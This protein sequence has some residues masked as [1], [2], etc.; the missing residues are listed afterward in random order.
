MRVEILLGAERSDCQTLSRVF[1]STCMQC[2]VN[3]W[4]C[5]FLNKFKYQ[6]LMPLIVLKLA[7]TI[8]WS[9]AFAEVDYNTVEVKKSTTPA[10]VVRKVSSVFERYQARSG[11]TF[12]LN[13]RRTSGAYAKEQ[14]LKSHRFGRVRLSGSARFSNATAGKILFDIDADDFP[15]GLGSSDTSAGFTE[16]ALLTLREINTRLDVTA[17]SLVRYGLI[18]Q[19]LGLDNSAS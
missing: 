4:K 9:P 12:A 15:I 18:E 10:S 5:G 6:G 1:E 2:A 19:P 8:G 3:I 13:H 7:V 14:T 16:S 17:I 11:V